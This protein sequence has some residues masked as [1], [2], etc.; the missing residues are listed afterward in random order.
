MLATLRLSALY[1]TLPYLG[2]CGKVANQTVH[3][4]F[5]QHPV[6]SIT[7]VATRLSCASPASRTCDYSGSCL[8]VRVGGSDPSSFEVRL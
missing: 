4:L 2:I 3:H 1:F 8:F 5:D 7:F 6:L